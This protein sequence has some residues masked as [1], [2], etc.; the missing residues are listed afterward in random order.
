MNMSYCRFENTLVDLKDCAT[1]LGINDETP[2]KM[3]YDEQRAAVELIELCA[4]IASQAAE[5]MTRRTDVDDLIGGG[6]REELKAYVASLDRL[7]KEEE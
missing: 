5:A 3:S 7:A 6:R 4:A 1:A 2:A